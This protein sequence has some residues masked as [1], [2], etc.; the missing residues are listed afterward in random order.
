MW[1]CKMTEAV[2]NELNV[3]QYVFSEVLNNIP[4]LGLE[5]SGLRT[6]LRTL[7]VLGKGSAT[8]LNPQPLLFL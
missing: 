8:E 2:I 5:F 3:L 7:H 4:P 1:F 6:K